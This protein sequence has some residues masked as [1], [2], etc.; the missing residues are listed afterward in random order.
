[1]TQR[2][3]GQS[4]TP[5]LLY[6]TVVFLFGNCFQSPVFGRELPKAATRSVMSTPA[7]DALRNL[8]TETKSK[9]MALTEH[10]K[11]IAKDLGFEESVLLL[12]KERLDP[13]MGIVKSGGLEMEDRSFLNED[14]NQPAKML[15]KDLKNYHDIASKYPELKKLVGFALPRNHSDLLEKNLAQYEAKQIERLGS[16]KFARMKA[17]RLAAEPFQSLIAQDHLDTHGRSKGGLVYVQKEPTGHLDSDEALKKAIADLQA[18]YDGKA[19]RPENKAK[20]M[21]G[22][23]YKGVGDHSFG[24]DR[25]MAALQAELQALGYRIADERGISLPRIHFETKAEAEKC[26]LDAGMIPDTL[27]ISHQQKSTY[28]AIYPIDCSKD[29]ASLEDSKIIALQSF[30]GSENESTAS[31]V[32]LLMSPASVWTEALLADAGLSLRLLPGS[33]V[34][35]LGDRR[36]LID[37]P[38]RFIATPRVRVSTVF[39]TPKASSGFDM[40]RAQ[41]TNG[42]NYGLSN[43]DVIEKLKYWDKKYGVTVVE[44]T[45]ESMKVSFKKLP[46]DLSE[47]CTE[48][49]LFCPDIE[50]STDEHSN[51]ARMRSM[52]DSLRQNKVMSFWWD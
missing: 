4:T 40:V 42:T 25:R 35:K 45:F 18:K 11:Q 9:N 14:H 27:G 51:A 44:A 10:E 28:K 43:E 24:D 30:D 50:M 12:I 21:L 48:F 38:E 2:R 46:A 1:M 37:V 19:L 15:E 26:L 49:F 32:K 3:L 47:L 41:G 23:K 31:L 29:F 13:E 7:I 39:K 33:A 36:W 6:I 17:Y 5:G 8:P 52:A 22:L 20:L 16:E 34:T